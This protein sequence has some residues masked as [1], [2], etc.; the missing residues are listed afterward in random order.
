MGHA[1][2]ARYVLFKSDSELLVDNWDGES[3]LSHSLYRKDTITG[4]IIRVDT[5]SDGTSFISGWSNKMQRFLM[6]VMLL[7]SLLLI[8]DLK[9]MKLL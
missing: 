5:L 1:K 6:T 4:D 8:Q 9:A 2:D 7:F 3:G